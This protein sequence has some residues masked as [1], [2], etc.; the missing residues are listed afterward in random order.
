MASLTDVAK[1]AGVSVTTASFVLNG[2]AAQKR[3]APQ[4]AQRVMDAVRELGYVP[5]VAARKLTG[6]NGSKSEPDIALMW[7]PELHPTFLGN[8]L[9]NAQ[10][11]FDAELVPRMRFAIAPFITSPAFRTELDLLARQYN[12]IMLSPFYEQELEWLSHC[13]LRIPAVVLHLQTD[14]HPNVVVDNYGTGKLAAEI[15]AARHHTS[16]AMLYRSS[17]GATSI[18]DLRQVGFSEECERQGM[19]FSGQPMPLFRFDSTQSRAEFGRIRATEYLQE[20]TLP[21]AVFIQDDAVAMGFAYALLIAGVRIP[22]DI[23]IITYGDDQLARAIHPGITTL[24]YPAPAITEQALRLLSQQ[25]LD[26]YAP[27]RQIAVMPTVT[28][29]GSCPQ[30]DGW[31]VK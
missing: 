4:T 30:P 22:E 27:P 1:A 20:K 9:T 8:F 11:L 13:P 10:H 26:P 16:A 28:F 14:R 25:L 7:S 23:E 17:V 18:P 3:I 12:G 6:H 31:D 24:D 21:E 19:R 29:R 2:Y 5:N 15:F